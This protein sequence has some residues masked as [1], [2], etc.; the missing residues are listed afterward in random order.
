M[1]VHLTLTPP[2]RTGF[3][4]FTLPFVP[5]NQM[6]T[7]WGFAYMVDGSPVM[8]ETLPAI[9]QENW[10]RGAVR[11]DNNFRFLRAGYAWLAATLFPWLHPP[12]SLIALNIMARCWH[13]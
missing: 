12:N 5:A 9:E 6:N 4:Y 13:A 8:S 10:F 7:L 2:G 3:L 11:S 1:L